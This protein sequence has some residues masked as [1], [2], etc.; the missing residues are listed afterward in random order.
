M[1]KILFLS[2]LIGM[3]FIGAASA[4]NITVYY[5]PSCPHCHH[6]REFIEGTLVYEYPTITV[7]NV[8]VMDQTNLPAFQDALTKCKYESG[9][10]PVIVIGDKC[11]QGYADFMQDELRTA[12]EVDLSAA[13]KQAAAENKAALA[14]NADEFKAAH[15]DR[16]GAVSEHSAAVADAQKKTN[17]NSTIWFYGLLIALVAA[18]GFVL[19]RRDNTKK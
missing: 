14:A 19:I 18:L 10:V 12:V 13:D 9:G 3:V 15:A 16:A 6:A 1:K 2:A 4:A 8:N 11:M 7:T 5:S 17:G